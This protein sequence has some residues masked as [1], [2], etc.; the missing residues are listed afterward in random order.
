MLTKNK[1]I[2]RIILIFFFISLFSNNNILLTKSTPTQN[3]P[4]N[5]IG[6]ILNQDGPFTVTDVGGPGVNSI[7]GFW[8]ALLGMKINEEKSF[9]I[10]AG[11]NPYTSGEVA[12][13]DL[14]YHVRIDTINIGLQVLEGVDA[15]TYYWLYL[16]C[17][18]QGTTTTTTGPFTTS[19]PPP[20]NTMLII[21][22]LGI[23][24]IGGG[25]F[26]YFTYLKPRLELPQD[27]VKLEQKQA[28]KQM[29]QAK[30]LLDLIQDKKEVSSKSQINK[31]P[32]KPKT[33]SRPRRR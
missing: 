28:K 21:G 22:G 33:G 9:I 20:D 23:V 19:A 7:T 29:N 2:L 13:K 1:L 4:D 26:G 18:V 16:D 12:G 25:V 10:P 3:I 8:Q 14:Y 5:W 6:C 32:T 30:E 15:T 27:T 24:V 31:S 11:E 17:S